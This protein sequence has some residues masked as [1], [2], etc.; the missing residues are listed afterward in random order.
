MILFLKGVD[1]EQLVTQMLKINYLVNNNKRKKI[2]FLQRI[3]QKRNRRNN[4]LLK[5]QQRNKEKNKN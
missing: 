2:P 1:L 4:K 5:Y 3:N